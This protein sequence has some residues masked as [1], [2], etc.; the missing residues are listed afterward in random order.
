MSEN[1][2]FNATLLGT[3]CP[4]VSPRRYGAG[5]LVECAGKC[6][7]VDIG[8]GVT[9]RLV[10]A[11]KSGADIDAVLL[12][13]LHSDHLVDLYQFII[14]SWHQNRDR[15]QVIYG[16]PGTQGFVDAQMQAWKAERTL[17]IEFEKRS[18]TAAFDIEVIEFEDSCAVISD[19]HST[20][21]AVRVE[22]PPVDPAFGYSFEAHGRKL[23]LSG[24][25][26]PCDNL[27]EAA[28]NADLMLHEVFAHAHD[29]QSQV[30]GTRTADTMAAVASYHTTA[31]E[32]GR[33]ARDADVRSLALTHIVPPDA[34]ERQLIAAVR[35]TYSGPVIVGE[36]LMS[37]D[38]MT[39]QVSWQQV[40][41][42]I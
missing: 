18:S 41:F 5:T 6:F 25:T 29:V 36:D 7:L 28:R 19:G 40:H 26:R 42:S 11:G 30:A 33:I 4:V 1:F 2:P 32:V 22:H 15:P 14:S 3:G 17:R 9:Q 35:R 37:F 10:E 8:S 20:I 27:I 39:G 13:H 24:D 16:P 21:R 34:D 12:T 31:D 23:V 38:L